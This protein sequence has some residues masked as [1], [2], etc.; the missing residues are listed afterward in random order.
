M[1]LTF[2]QKNIPLAKLLVEN[3]CQINVATIDDPLVPP[4]T[5][6]HSLAYDIFEPGD[7]SLVIKFLAQTVSS[8][9]YLWI[10]VMTRALDAVY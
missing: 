7:P 9:C 3:G 4:S 10:I 2:L 5:L 1:Y 6:L 8:S